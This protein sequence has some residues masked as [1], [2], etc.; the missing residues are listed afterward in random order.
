MSRHIWI[1]SRITSGAF[2]LIDPSS[3]SLSADDSSIETKIYSYSSALRSFSTKLTSSNYAKVIMS[4]V[5]S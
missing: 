1:P 5:C 2:V 3:E 4:P